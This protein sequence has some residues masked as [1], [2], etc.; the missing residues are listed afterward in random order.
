MPRTPPDAALT[1]AQIAALVADARQGQRDAIEARYQLERAKC[2]ALGGAR[3][4]NCYIDAHAHKG[5]AMLEA[6]GPYA[7]RG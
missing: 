4:D 7:D 6:A 1:Q 5:R 3:R 2:D